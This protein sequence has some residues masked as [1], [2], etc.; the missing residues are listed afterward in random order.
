MDMQTVN[1]QQA[2]KLIIS[3]GRTNTVM[4][5]GEPGC[6]KS[7]IGAVVARALDMKFVYIDAPVTD[8]P[9]IG[10][11]TV[12]NGRTF[13][14]LHEQ[15]SP[16]VPCVYMIDELSKATGPAKLT[17]T[18]FLLERN[19]A[20]Y[21][22]H[23]NSI[24]MGTGNLS[25]DAVGD[26]MQGHTNNRITNVQ[27]RKPTTEE[28]VDWGINNSINPLVL[29]WVDQF[30]ESMETYTDKSSID[31]KYIFNPKTRTQA[32]V[33]PRS[34]ELVS[35]II[36][37]RDELGDELTRIA[38]CGTVGAS[39]GM[40]MSAWFS[41]SD[42]L[43]R[44]EAVLKT[45]ELALLPT[46]V[47]A[48]LM[49]V[50]SLIAAVDDKVLNFDSIFTYVLRMPI[51]LQAVFGRSIARS[52]ARDIAFKSSRFTTWLANSSAMLG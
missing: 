20:G 48:Q 28:W 32:F 19:I 12:V 7:S 51:E 40:D 27:I 37:K 36:D 8:I 3:V 52:P 10:M 41:L 31:N 46:N 14:A 24:I 21:Q 23:P 2:V 17:F 29:A 6:A 34:L 45:P 38:M 15:W 4:V 22:V 5:R 47:A 43:P 50:F 11:P 16:D 25:T 44:R 49:M 18:R 39:A 42:K 13:T 30:P 33:S 35:K 1:F 9:E 26:T